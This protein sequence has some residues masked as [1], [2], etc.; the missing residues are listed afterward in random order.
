M[1]AEFILSFEDDQWY[2][3][4]KSRVAKKIKCLASFYEKVGIWE[5][6]MVSSKYTEERQ[7]KFDVRLFLNETSI[8]IEVSS[9]PSNIENDLNHLFEWIR[10]NTPIT[11]ADEDG[12]KSAW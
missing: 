6:R 3:A 11:I 10:S 5:F 12:V 1:A 7:M 8:F 2:L 9:H 4:N